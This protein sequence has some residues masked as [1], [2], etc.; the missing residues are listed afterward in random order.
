MLKYKCEEVSYESGKISEEKIHK[1]EQSFGL[2][3]NISFFIEILMTHWCKFLRYMSSNGYTKNNNN[4]LC[5]S[6]RYLFKFPNNK[7]LERKGLK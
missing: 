6:F 3:C 2:K 5:K 4:P 1:S 7:E